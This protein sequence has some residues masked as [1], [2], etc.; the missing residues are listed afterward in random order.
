MKT[1]RKHSGFSLVET[2]VAMCIF[3]LAV[4]VL[5]ESASIALNGI[6]IM[7]IKEGND[8]AYQFVRDQILTISDTDSL[9][10][11][12]QV[13]TPSAG[14]ANW[15]VVETE[16]TPTPDL[17]QVT[18]NITL[19]GNGDVPP[20]STTQTL[21]LL[22]PQWSDTDARAAAQSSIHDDLSN[23]RTQQNWP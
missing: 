5:A 15:Q 3:I 16:T 14:D 19:S 2:L 7:E 13:N 23:W 9:S 18:I 12:G 22:R 6:A 20:D 1:S 8:R 4:G 21:L 17:F 10:M 11:G